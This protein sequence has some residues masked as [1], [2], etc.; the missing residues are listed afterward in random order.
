MQED[1]SSF[2]R[3]NVQ[4]FNADTYQTNETIAVGLKEKKK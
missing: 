2:S 3:K 1:A 4:P